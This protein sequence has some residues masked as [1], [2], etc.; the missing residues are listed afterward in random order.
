M[1]LRYPRCGEPWLAPLRDSLQQNQLGR[2]QQCNTKE[3]RRVAHP[4]IYPLDERFSAQTCVLSRPTCRLEW[5]VSGSG[6]TLKYF[7]RIT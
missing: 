4:D 6:K 1:R 2:S 7:R 5:G 3:I